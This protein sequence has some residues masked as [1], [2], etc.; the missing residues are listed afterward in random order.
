M[1]ESTKPSGGPPR[2]QPM[3]HVEDMAAAVA[4]YEALG[5]GGA[6]G[7]PGR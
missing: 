6:A 7:E 1:S 5:G 3:V 2:L 4:F